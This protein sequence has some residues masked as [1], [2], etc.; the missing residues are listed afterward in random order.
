VSDGRKPL[1]VAPTPFPGAPSVTLFR[2]TW[3]EHITKQ[4]VE[5][6]GQ[7]AAVEAVVT[8]PTVVLAGHADTPHVVFINQAVTSQSGTPLA[9]I[10]HPEEKIICTAYYNRSFRII[11][12]D[13]TL[14]LRPEIK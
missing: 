9:V 7:E 2:D 3:I 14:W 11:P 13:A 4:H 8:S 10:V 1:F 5:L 6:T 12:A